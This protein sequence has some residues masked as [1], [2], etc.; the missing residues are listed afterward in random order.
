MDTCDTHPTTDNHLT[1]KPWIYNAPIYKGG[2]ADV[3]GQRAVKL[4]SN[5]NPFGSSSMA[6]EAYKRAAEDLALYPEGSAE[7]LRNAIAEY[8]Q[9]EADRIVCSA[10][11]DELLFLL[12]RAYLSEG[13]E[14]VKSQYGFAIYGIAALQMGATIVNAAEDDLVPSV[15][16]MLASVTD[17]TRIVFVAN[18]NNP[19][20]AYLSA[21]EIKRL[22]EN[23][24]E[25]IVLVLDEAYA[26]YMQADDYETGL[27][28]ARDAKNI[29]VTRT[30]SKI[31]GL[32]GLRIGWCYTSPEIVDV[33]NRVRSPFNASVPAQAAAVAALK[34]K[35][36]V[37]ASLTHNTKWLAWMTGEITALGLRVYPSV[38]NFVLVDFAGITDKTAADADEFLQQNG[39]IVRPVG[40]YGLP[41]CLRISIGKEEHCRGVVNALRAFLQ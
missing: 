36:F 27:G 20:G 38:C 39:F 35:Q 18:P 22:H 11:S 5:E 13:D 37:H 33:L 7:N 21:S 24:R 40:G 3:N 28:L 31:H 2:K 8:E 19:T 23:L 6:Q 32:A 17:K 29:V 25:D 10:G 26:E 15:D 4:S 1:A 34:D 12:A 41:S 30:F 16:A 9:L 14:I